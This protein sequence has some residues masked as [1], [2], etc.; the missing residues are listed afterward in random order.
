[1]AFLKRSCR[2]V[3]ALLVARED[4]ALGLADQIAL[5][6]HLTVCDACPNFER[7]M[8]SLRHGMARWRSAADSDTDSDPRLG[9]GPS[10]KLACAVSPAAASQAAGQSK[11][12]MFWMRYQRLILLLLFL[13]LLLALLQWS[14]LR[15]NFSLEALRQQLSASHWRG[16]SIFVLLFILGNLVHLPGWI[17]LAAAVLVLGKL[18]GGLVTYVAASLSCAITFWTVRWV[19][20]DA[21]RHLPGKLAT[22]LLAQLNAHPLRN[23]VIL[24]TIFQTLPALN[25]A[26]ALSGV[27]FKKYLLATLLGLPLP[28]AAYCLF[29]DFIARLTHLA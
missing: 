13:A 3:A 29:F 16:L 25:Y 9:D 6:M 17:F 19:G 24:R 4:R 23:I 20:G 14:G 1:M 5:R 21:F 26:L 10:A 27:S 15:Q 28:I 12:L 22:R 18:E 11:A 7:Q 8:L 2:D